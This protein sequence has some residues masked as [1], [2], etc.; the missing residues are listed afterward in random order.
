MLCSYG[1]PHKQVLTCVCHLDFFA[2]PNDLKVLYLKPTW[3]VTTFAITVSK[4][5]YMQTQHTFTLYPVCTVQSITAQIDKP[6]IKYAGKNV[7]L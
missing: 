4:R 1:T 5:I 3:Y 2:P 6:K 7:P